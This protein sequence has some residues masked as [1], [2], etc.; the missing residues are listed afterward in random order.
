MTHQLHIP[1]QCTRLARIRS[2]ATTSPPKSAT[3]SPKT[4]CADAMAEKS[5]EVSSLRPDRR[6]ERNVQSYRNLVEGGHSL[7]LCSGPAWFAPY[8]VILRG[9]RMVLY[10]CQKSHF[11]PFQSS[12]SLTSL[13]WCRRYPNLIRR[14]QIHIRHFRPQLYGLQTRF[15]RRLGKKCQE[16]LMSQPVRQILQIRCEGNRRPIESDGI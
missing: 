10:P 11:S 5:A 3:G 1:M 7:Q 6:L 12:I 15:L 13:L 8:T 16:I 9:S 2:R 14:Y 4:P